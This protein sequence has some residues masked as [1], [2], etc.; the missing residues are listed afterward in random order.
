MDEL[1]PWCSAHPAPIWDGVDLAPCFRRKVLNGII[2]LA[3]LALSGLVVVGVLLQ[4]LIFH[5]NTKSSTSSH[6]KKSK[7]SEAEE[8]EIR[9]AATPAAL[10]TAALESTSDAYTR[11]N[12]FKIVI[13]V[14]VL[15]NLGFQIA[16]FIILEQSHE[17]GSRWLAVSVGAW[18][19]IA[20]IMIFPSGGIPVDYIILPWLA[21]SVVTSF[22]DLR[23]AAL[24]ATG[25]LALD[26][27]IFSITACITLLVLITPRP[28]PSLHPSSDDI[29]PPLEL[30]SSL[31]SST[32]FSFLDPLL[33]K[34]AFP[35]PKE[36][37]YSIKTIPDLLPT[38]QCAP[39]MG[40]YRDDLAFLNASRA[41]KGQKPRGL[42]ISLFWYNRELFLGAIVWSFL[43]VAVVAV[44]TLLF[45]MPLQSFVVKI[46]Q[47]YQ[48]R[49][50]KAADARV[51]FTKEVIHGIRL[52]KYE[53]WE[54]QLAAKMGVLRQTEL[55]AIWTKSLISIVD[56][57]IMSGT[58]ICVA[59]VTFLCHTK[60]LLFSE[61][62]LM[63]IVASFVAL[64]RIETFLREPDTRKYDVLQSTTPLQVGFEKA[65]FT[66]ASNPDEELGPNDFALR[67]ISLDFPIGKLTAIVGRVGSGK[68]TLL[69]SLLGE[70][71]LISGRIFLPSPIKRP[72]ES[73]VLTDSVAY[74]AQTPFLLSDTIEANVLFG[75]SKDE[76]RYSQVLDAC[77][78]TPDL[79]MFELGDAT[80]VGECGIV[81]SGGQKARISLAR[82]VYSSAKVLLL[83]DI[84]SA[85]DTHTASHLVH[86]CLA[87]G[88]PDS[89]L[90]ETSLTDLEK[91]ATKS[92]EAAAPIEDLKPESI[93]AR[94]ARAAKLKLVQAET[95]RTG[96]I[97]LKL[98]MFYIRALGGWWICAIAFGFFAGAQLSEI[99]FYLKV[100][101]LL[102]LL[103]LVLFAARVAFWLRRA[104][105]AARGIYDRLISSLLGATVRF[106]D[107]TPTGRIINRISSDTSTVDGRLA[108][109]QMYLIFELFGV[110]GIIA[111]ITLVYPAFLL[112]AAVISLLYIAI[113]Y[114][115]LSAC[116]EFQRSASVAK[117]PVFNLFGEAINGVETIRAYGDSMRFLRQILGLLDTSTR[118]FYATVLSN[119]WLSIRCDAAG[120]AVSFAA[121]LFTIFSSRTM[122]A[123]LAGFVLSY[124]LNFSE[125]T[126]WTVRFW[127][128][129]AVN[130][131]ALERV[132]EYTEIDQE[133]QGGLVPPAIWPSRD[134]SIEVEDLCVR[135]TA[136]LPLALQGVSFKVKPREKVG[137]VGRTGSGK[138]TLTLSFFRFVEASAGKIIID[139]IDIRTLSLA[140]L[141]SRLVIVPQDSILMSGPLRESL[142]PF[143]SFSDADLWEVVRQVHLAAPVD[144]ATAP[145]QRFVVTSLD[146]EVENGGKNFSAGE[147]QLVALAR[148]LL[149]LR[150][151]S[152]L[153]LD[154]ST[155]SLDHAT[156]AKIQATLREVMPD[157]TVLCVAREW[158][159]AEP[160]IGLYY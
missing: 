72:L 44:A 109:L 31:L 113:G 133:T 128:G 4:H 22:L 24:F 9:A 132:K 144:G 30:H 108:G 119:R 82:A 140:Q 52:V 27:T 47:R 111:T 18:T 106:Y 23:S 21:V 158:P 85:V 56:T 90:R 49:L 37:P 42:L 79:A 99:D 45:F 97:S 130:M 70:T 43:K 143:G 154:E 76:D 86:S 78:L 25:T 114:L 33:F 19:W 123:A 110:V 136:D 46:F 5:P 63:D 137:I 149:K 100:Y 157:A 142:D 32:T 53:A 1:D 94:K 155:A 126:L 95:Q 11:R 152:I 117:S 84:L 48:T 131:N 146:M 6:D 112:P 89:V 15:S 35:N 57:L 150:S 81:L 125:K 120:A 14:G 66:W 38:D 96:S 91:S 124:A 28:S 13:A 12:L 145:D 75:T 139:G 39:N 20:I 103:D 135:Y 55:A 87:A 36:P 93:E 16:R 60:G 105:S 3:F 34:M 101:C 40:R 50:R 65:S 118:C 26:A 83:D 71:T 116:Q 51:A 153:I 54:S 129:T 80:E 92:I 7:I 156:D 104:L 134:G 121:A 122:D 69:T 147:R 138:S 127:V 68:S 151:S 160:I 115:Y 61:I 141:R 74:C 8:K 29:P 159:T 73:A 10:P 148:A 64:R 98:Y 58:P 88:A 17:L 59:V 41:A 67:D 107:S 102:S 77:A 2:P 62:F